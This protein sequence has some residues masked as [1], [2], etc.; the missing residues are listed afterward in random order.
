LNEKPHHQVTAGII[1]RAG[2]ILISRRPEGVH[3]AGLWEFPG[4]KQEQGE[5]LEACLVREIQEELGVTVVPGRHLLT[6]EHE[7]K[8]KRVTLHFFTCSLADGET[9]VALEG[10]ELTWVSPDALSAFRFPPPDQNVITLLQSLG[11]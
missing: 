10:Q 1:R 11:P 3:L 4:G 7:Y 5:S 2:K 6:E 8:N 9:P